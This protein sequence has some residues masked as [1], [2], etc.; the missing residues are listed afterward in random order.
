MTGVQTCAL[1]IYLNGLGVPKSV[2]FAKT[3]EQRKILELGYAQEPIGRPYYLAEEVPRERVE[4]I[5]RAF[6]ATFNDP[7][8]I[9]E[10]KRIG[11]DIDWADGA[12][13]QAHVEKVFATPADIVAKTRKALRPEG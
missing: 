13:V 11:L 10:S 6:A 7:A 9:A 8:F 2:D 1:P 4:A 3:E 5:R 12:S